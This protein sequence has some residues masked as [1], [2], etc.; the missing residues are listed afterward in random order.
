MRMKSEKKSF[1]GF[2]RYMLEI[3]IRGA[4]EVWRRLGGLILVSVLIVSITM[5]ILG[6]LGSI[7]YFVD[8]SGLDIGW[9]G[10]LDQWHW[11]VVSLVGYFS[12]WTIFYHYYG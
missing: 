2:C 1:V 12:M 10:L 4:K 5:V 8:P 7:A 6:V 9:Y 11:V 3:H